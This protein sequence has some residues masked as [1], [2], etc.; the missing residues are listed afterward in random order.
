MAVYTNFGGMDELLLQ[1]WRDGFARFGAAL[2][3]PPTTDDPMADFV[4][5]GW[6]YRRFALDNRHLYRVM[7]G[8]GLVPFRFDDPADQ[9][10]R[11][12]HVRVAALPPAQCRRPRPPA[13]RRRRARRPGRVVDRPRPHDHRADRLLRGASGRIRCRSTRSACAASPWPSATIAATWRARCGR[14]AAARTAPHL[15]MPPDLRLFA[16]AAWA[17]CHDVCRWPPRAGLITSARR[18]SSARPG[19][20]DMGQRTTA[21]RTRRRTT[22]EAAGA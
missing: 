13:G 11:P 1:V 18:M 14:R 2:D 5:Q 12:G 6:G 9:Q 7:F 20:V 19:G 4:E 22:F 17:G 3:G 15:L 8:D 21:R 10:A 16:P